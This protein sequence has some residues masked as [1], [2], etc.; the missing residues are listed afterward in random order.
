[1]AEQ[2]EKKCNSIVKIDWEILSELDQTPT[3]IEVDTP[4]DFKEFN[5]AINKLTLH[6]A[7]ELNQVSPNSI[8]VLD[9]DN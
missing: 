3:H 2:F 7:T 5:Y 1:M 6:K 9:D 8:K 4:L